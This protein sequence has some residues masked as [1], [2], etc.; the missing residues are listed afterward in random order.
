MSIWHK[1]HIKIWKE[2]L[3]IHPIIV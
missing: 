2:N 1:K 3:F